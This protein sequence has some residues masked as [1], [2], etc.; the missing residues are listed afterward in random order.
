MIQIS[1]YLLIILI[2]VDAFIGISGV[3]WILL[4][5]DLLAADAVMTIYPC[6]YEDHRTSMRASLILGCVIVLVSIVPGQSMDAPSKAALVSVVSMLGVGVYLAVRTKSRYARGSDLFSMFSIWYSLEDYSHLIWIFSLSLSGLILVV[7]SGMHGWEV[8]VVA[9]F[10]ALFLAGLHVILLLRACRGRTM[11]LDRKYENEVLSM[12]NGRIRDA[13]ADEGMDGL[14]RRVEKY[15]VEKKPFLK[16]DFDL[17][18]LSHEV[19]SNRLYLSKT[20]RQ[21]SGKNFCQYVN[22]YRLKYATDRLMETDARIADVALEAGFHSISTFNMAFKAYY[23]L[24]PTEWLQMKKIEQ[25]RQR[26][27]HHS[28]SKEQVQ[29]YEPQSS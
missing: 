19:F 2:F 22:G 17:N 20:I 26:R 27:Q 29:G 11:L 15:M 10:E 24:T 6:S 9:S 8:Y 18:T 16:D 23:E 28:S 21:C 4:L 14:F 7:I 3:S 1:W 12:I 25:R 13:H 5:A